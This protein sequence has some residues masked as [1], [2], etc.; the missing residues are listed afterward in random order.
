MKAK[1]PEKYVQAFL[2]TSRLMDKYRVTHFIYGIF[3][4]PGETKETLQETRQFWTRYYQQHPGGYGFFL[5]Q[6]FAFF[7]GCEVYTN[8]GHYQREY[9]TQVLHPE[10]WKIARPS[11]VKPLHF[12]SP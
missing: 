7:P 4:Y 12:S 6:P 8:F 11:H 5:A 1:N 9:G 3:N 10:W 2:E